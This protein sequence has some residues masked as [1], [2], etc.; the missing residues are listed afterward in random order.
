MQAIAGLST[1][2]SVPFWKLDPIKESV[3]EAPPTVIE[4]QRS[5]PRTDTVNWAA[6]V[7]RLAAIQSSDA[8]S[9]VWFRYARERAKWPE[10]S[11]LYLTMLSCQ[12]SDPITDTSCIL[13]H[14]QLQK[15][16]QPIADRSAMVYL[17]KLVSRGLVAPEIRD[18]ARGLW[19]RLQASY[20]N[21]LPEPDAAP[22]GEGGVMLAFD[23]GL[24]HLE[25][26]IIG[27]KQAE[28]YF[29]KRDTN[30]MWDIEATDR[31]ALPECVLLAL[32]L[33]MTV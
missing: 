15:M 4:E 23:D 32:R 30:E 29:L 12:Y 24:N 20:T 27:E 16:G 31:E 33:F 9:R 17:D 19:N 25:F 7:D 14:E 18:T 5:E 11:R 21:R 26:E 8:V 1:T 28:V 3:N 13:P 22:T 2:K 10:L 6:L